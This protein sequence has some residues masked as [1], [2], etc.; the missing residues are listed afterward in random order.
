MTDA[1][2]DPNVVFPIEP[3][4]RLVHDGTIGT[5]AP[6]QLTFMGGIY[7]QRRLHQELLPALV[8]EIVALEPD[9]VLLVP[10]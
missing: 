10:V 2:I 9:V 7:S 4:R 3:L 8:D 6:H 5:L 1:R